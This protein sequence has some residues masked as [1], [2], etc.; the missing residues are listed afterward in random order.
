MYSG[1]LTRPNNIVLGQGATPCSNIQEREYGPKRYNKRLIPTGS[2]VL[3]T[4]KRHN[5]LLL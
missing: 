1:L 4:Q 5:V 3:N 2:V